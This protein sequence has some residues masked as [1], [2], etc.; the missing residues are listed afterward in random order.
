MKES[1][2]QTAIAFGNLYRGL[3]KSCRN[4]RWKDS[5]ISYE[6]NALKNTLKLRKSILDGTYKISK[7]QIFQIFEPKKRVIVASRLVDR[8]FQRALCDAGLYQDIVEHFIRDNVACQVGKGTDDAIKRLKIQL[9]RYY[10]KHGS[11]GWALKCD[12]YHFFPETQHEVAK[13]AVRKYVSDKEAAEAVCVVIDS[14]EGDKGIGLGSQISQLIELLVLN[15]MDHYIKERLH[16][17]YYVRYMDDFILIHEDRVYLKH[18]REEI[19]GILAGL[20]LKLN[21]KTCIYPLS[22]GV[23]FLKWRFVLTD[24]GKILML[25]DRQKLKKQRTRMKK[26]WALEQAGKVEIGTT[27]ASLQSWLSNA[28]R[29]DTH[30]RQKRMVNFYENLI[31]G[32]SSYDKKVSRAKS[33]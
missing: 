27:E 11:K 6:N 2:F 5:V 4:V 24:T 20:G 32:G 28:K 3:K 21:E 9:H 7:Y 17:K 23:K 13:R 12:V 22:Q 14:F 31:E 1:Y 10:R 26:L 30:Y 18:C 8:Q 19:K 15:D 33:A 25:M 16:I 29:G